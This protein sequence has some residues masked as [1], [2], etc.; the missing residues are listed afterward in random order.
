M[1]TIKMFV[2]SCTIIFAAMLM[3]SARLSAATPETIPVKGMVTLV[4][5][6]ATTCI[7]CRMMAPILEELKEEYKGKAEV[8]FIDVWDK[9]NAGKAQAYKIMAIPTQVF[10]DKQGRE[11]YRHT[12]FLDKKTIVEKLEGLLA[13]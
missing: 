10:F 1:R 3:H 9:A 2:V 13:Q 11:A 8:I 7:P 12:G 4:D 6:G 5:F